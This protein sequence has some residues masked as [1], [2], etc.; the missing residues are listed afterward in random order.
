MNTHQVGVLR[1]AI[2]TM[3]HVH[4]DIEPHGCSHVTFIN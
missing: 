1:I 2:V 3:T 4:F